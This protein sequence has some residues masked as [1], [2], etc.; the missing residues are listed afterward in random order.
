MTLPLE[1]EIAHYRHWR[2]ELIATIGAY[3]SW[4]DSTGQGDVEQSL[5]IFDLLESLG[6]DRL[7]LAFVAE[8]SRGK[9]ELINALF[10]S[11]FR[12]RLLPSDVG[13]TT[14]CPTEIFY[15]PAEA[16]YIRLLPIETRRRDESI[17]A[18]KR[19]PVE[20][21]M[22]RLD[23]TSG[24][25]MAE[26][27]RTVAQTKSVSEE[28]ARALGLWVDSDPCLQYSKQEDGR[29]EIPA[30][31]HALINI[32]HP[33][34]EAGLVILDTPGLNALGTEPE[35]TLD[36]IPSAHAVLFLLDMTTGATKSDLD[37]WH[38]FIQKSMSRRLAVL[39]K[40]D[41]LWDELKPW[42][43]IKASLQRQ[44]EATARLLELP[45]ASVFAVSAQK[46]LLARIRGDG[47]LL[48]K[49]G[50][51]ALE[52]ALARDI[53]PA[54][55]HLLR[56]TALR[57]L[58][59]MVEASKKAVD[60]RLASV[61][62][63]RKELASL[64][65]K[66]REAIKNLL[67][68]AQAEKA[69]YEHVVSSFNATRGVVSRQGRLLMSEFSADKLER[70]LA[71][72]RENIVG[73]WTTPGLFR[74]MQ[75]LFEQAA[76][77][78]EKIHVLSKQIKV[79]VDAAYKRFHEQH[80]FAELSPPP[81]ELEPFSL[82]LLELVKKTEEFC[83]DPV[84]LVTEKHFLIRKFHLGLESRA[85]QIFMQAKGK[86]EVWV[87]AALSPL[88]VQIRENKT[89]IERR[90]KNI[91]QIHDNIDSLEERIRKLAEEQAE[92]EEHSA[93][94]ARIRAKLQPPS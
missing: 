78:F 75:S 37:I 6:K 48:E 32:P 23:P 16:P 30:W 34:L 46:A 44:V 51:E 1:L 19:M 45:P 5:K 26:A 77:Q 69:R 92:V 68:Q 3:Q 35:L 82:A 66:N 56:S 57:E 24:S 10:F 17:A 36:M 53:V 81:L 50:I 88:T 55:Q 49:S 59:S 40:A 58:G 64:A 67:D 60:D 83:A 63:E 87:G 31:R 61:R 38:R 52:T 84:N 15:D 42:E 18:L 28:E 29:V 70:L 90:L 13:R 2:E 12:Q 39:N 71:K 14:M 76:R 72:S 80:G 79:L 25:N 11:D 89:Q 47:T 91:R 54:K 41:V 21:S 8:F 94:I 85:R 4:L 9:T 93:A 65:G 74:S 73:S 86:S 33:L 22:V 27:M 62:H 20:W 7:V 43:Q